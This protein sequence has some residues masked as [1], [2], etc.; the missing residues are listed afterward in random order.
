[1]AASKLRPNFQPHLVGGALRA[2][3]RRVENAMVELFP[4]FRSNVRA[5]PGFH[6]KE[7]VNGSSPLEG[8]PISRPRIVEA[9]CGVARSE[10][11]RRVMAIA[12]PH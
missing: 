11:S 3:R 9:P 2:V 5:T 4:S 6:G 7:G 8:F 10:P 12:R 1:M